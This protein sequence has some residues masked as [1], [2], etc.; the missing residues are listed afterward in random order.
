[1]N[2]NFMNKTILTASVLAIF[3]ISVPNAYAGCGCPKQYD[4][5][6]KTSNFSWNIFKGFKNC[7]PCIK[8]KKV[9]IKCPKQ[10]KSKCNKCTGAAAPAAQPDTCEKAF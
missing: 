6:E 1:M 10:A 8:E 7:N 5:V 4:T 3:L 2:N 9:K